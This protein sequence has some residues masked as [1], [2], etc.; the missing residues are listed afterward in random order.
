MVS[1]GSLEYYL[2]QSLAQPEPLSLGLSDLVLESHRV[3][4]FSQVSQQVILYPGPDQL[5]NHLIPHV[6]QKLI[7]QL[8]QLITWL[9]PHM[10]EV[11]ADSEV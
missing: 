4:W 1:A 8:K 9:T 5:Q 2:F 7:D 6:A 3:C 11:V 10:S